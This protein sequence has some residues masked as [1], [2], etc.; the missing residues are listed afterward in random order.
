[1]SNTDSTGAG[2]LGSLWGWGGS[3]VSVK[4]GTRTTGLLLSALFTFSRL[5]IA[6]SDALVKPRVSLKKYVKENENAVGEDLLAARGSQVR[7]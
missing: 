3:V 6:F 5:Q 2:G 1:M 4:A 7:D